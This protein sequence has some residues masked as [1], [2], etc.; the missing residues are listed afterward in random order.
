MTLTHRTFQPLFRPGVYSRDMTVNVY[1]YYANKLAIEEAQKQ[2]PR[3][4]KSKRSRRAR[5]SVPALVQ[6]GL[7]SGFAC[8]AGLTLVY[9]PAQPPYLLFV[10]SAWGVM[11]GWVAEAIRRRINK[12]MAV[13]QGA[14][15]DQDDLRALTG[16]S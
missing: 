13:L 3:V 4:L 12:F 15:L 16:R 9:C 2:Q 6:L 14:P 10:G 8:S 1:T 5:L 11:L 7:A